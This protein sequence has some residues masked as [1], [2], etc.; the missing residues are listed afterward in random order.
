ME[1]AVT[2]FGITLVL[3]LITKILQRKLI[4]KNEMK[5]FQEES[6]EMQK[7]LRELMKEAE[8]I[9]RRLMSCKQKC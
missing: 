2:I 9:K 7:E 5:K 3:A 6:K 1:A 8:K 4:D